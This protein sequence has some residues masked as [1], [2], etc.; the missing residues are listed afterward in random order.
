MKTCRE[1][2]ITHKWRVLVIVIILAVFAL[3]FGLLYHFLQPK[4]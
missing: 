2:L 1:R 3:L 4:A